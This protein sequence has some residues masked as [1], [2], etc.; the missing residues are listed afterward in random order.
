MISLGIAEMVAACALMFPGFFGGEGGIATNRQ[1]GHG[2]ARHH[3]RAADPGLLPDRG[4][5]FVCMI[6]MFAFTQTPLGRMANAV[7]DNPERAE[8][9]GYNPTR[10]RYLMLCLAAFFA[11]IAGGLGT[12]NYEIVTAEN[13]GVAR[14]GQRADHGLRRRRGPLLRPD[15]RRGAGL[16]P[17]VGAVQLHAGLAA[18]LR[19]VLHVH[20]HVRARR[21]RQPDHVHGPALRA[22]PASRGCAG[23]LLAAWRSLVLLA[24]GHRAD[25]D[26]LSPGAESERGQAVQA[27]LAGARPVAARPSWIVAGLVF[28][29]GLGL[30]L[31]SLRPGAR[32]VAGGQRRAAGAR[33]AHD[34]AALSS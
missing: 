5:C 3:L 4:W 20:D 9:V 25:R 34:R 15:H 30:F 10:V 27:V 24:G 33:C 19:P 12:I 7:R 18:V 32:G 22:R 14:F 17:A 16:V 29:V 21:D 23:Y 1:V 6:A 31:A 2:V 8:F 11:G 28:V 13:V 26:D